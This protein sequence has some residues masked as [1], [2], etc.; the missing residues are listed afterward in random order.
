M[1]T[2]QTAGCL[3]ASAALLTSCSLLPGSSDSS[4]KPPAKK[5][6][7]KAPPVSDAKVKVEIKVTGDASVR[8]FMPGVLFE[9][10][11][12]TTGKN[13]DI[14]VD[15]VRTPWSKTFTSKPGR[16]L[17]L[18]VA[19]NT[20]KKEVGCQIYVDGHLKADRTE[21]MKPGYAL[22]TMCNTTA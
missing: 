3:L 19:S 6:S 14:D 10:G 8:A 12:K 21:E 20:P 17:N 5:V 22:A 7:T 2:Y 1:R 18:Q 11:E 16:S 4:E 13:A 9:P 15:E